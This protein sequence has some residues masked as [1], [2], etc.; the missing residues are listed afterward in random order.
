MATIA[1]RPLRRIVLVPTCHDSI[2]S[3]DRVSGHAGVIHHDGLARYRL[4]ERAK[5]EASI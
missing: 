5:T 4:V 1:A 2:S 3:E